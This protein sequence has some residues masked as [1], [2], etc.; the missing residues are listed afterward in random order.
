MNVKTYD[1]ILERIAYIIKKSSSSPEELRTINYFR[2][3]KE[4]QKEFEELLKLE[5]VWYELENNLNNY[6]NCTIELKFELERIKNDNN[7]ETVNRL[8]TIL[9]STSNCTPFELE[10]IDDYMVRKEDVK[11]FHILT[12]QLHIGPYKPLKMSSKEE[13]ENLKQKIGRKK[14]S[15]QRISSQINHDETIKDEVSFI[16]S[17]YRNIIL[18]YNREIIN[19]EDLK[20]LTN[21]YNDIEY[22]SIL[23]ELRKYMLITE[24]E[25]QDLLTYRTGKAI[26]AN[27]IDELVDFFSNIHDIKIEQINKLKSILTP[28]ELDEL[29]FELVKRGTFTFDEYIEDNFFEMS[30][31]KYTK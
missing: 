23:N 25:Y 24:E 31:E 15:Y 29:K 14:A 13:R 17:K 27:S 3:K 5:S 4:Y 7:E 6:I 21:I 18:M 11:E 30:E 1:Q 12:K 8:L 22:L 20:E 2:V 9:N 26:Y 10:I 28:Y 16:D 19:K